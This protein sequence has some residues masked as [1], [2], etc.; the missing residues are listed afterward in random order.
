MTYRWRTRIYVVFHVDMVVFRAVVVGCHK[1]PFT[2]Y[3]M[4]M[5]TRQHVP[6]PDRQ[7]AFC[8]RN[9]TLH[10]NQLFLI[11]WSQ[12]EGLRAPGTSGPFHFG[13]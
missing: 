12:R 4:L 5:L 11:F 2:K 7:T 1:I 10:F 13:L 8:P 9:L 6:S 3:S